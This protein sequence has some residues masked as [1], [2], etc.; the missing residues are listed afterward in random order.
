MGNSK[1]SDEFKLQVVTEYLQGNLGCRTIAKKY[2]LPSK[3]YVLRW[4]EELI[5]KGLLLN[6]PEHSKHKNKVEHNITKGKTAYEKQLERENF[7][8]KARLAYF[9]ELEKLM[10]DCKKK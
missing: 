10:D 8:L 2:N 5:K 9:K 6:L 3:N 4:K 7:E 1:Y